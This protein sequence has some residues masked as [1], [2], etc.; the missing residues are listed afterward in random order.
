[1][2]TVPVAK[3]FI[4][5]ITSPDENNAVMIEADTAEPDIN[6][7]LII[8]RE[9]S[10]FAEPIIS[11]LLFADPMINIDDYVSRISYVSVR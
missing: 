9:Q 11:K 5:V 2:I 4:P 3:N 6:T 7:E 1:M 8:N 10:M